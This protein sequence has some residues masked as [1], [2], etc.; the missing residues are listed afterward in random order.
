M[1]GVGLVYNP[2]LA[3]LI[4]SHREVLDFVVISPEQFFHDRGA[5]NKS[6][7]PRYTEHEELLGIMIDAVGDL[8]LVAH[9]LRLS[10]GTEGDL[11]KGHL[12]QMLRWQEAFNFRW[13]SE[14]LSFST[15]GAAFDYKELG[16]MLPVTYDEVTLKSLTKRVAE[17]SCVLPVEFLLENAVNYTPLG[18]C[19]YTEC[20]FLN[21][22]CQRTDAKLLLDLH[23]L[24][25]NLRN[26]YGA[27]EVLEAK[28]I[29]AI[30][31]VDISHIREI[32]IAGGAEI[33]GVW[34]DSHSGF[35]PEEVWN[36]LQHILS[37][38]HH[39][40]GVTYEID[41]SCVSL[42]GED[43]IVNMLRHVRQ[44]ITASS[45]SVLR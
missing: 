45:G 44:L 11:D 34:T 37:K 26:Q 22:L 14:H 25:T 7:L 6:S 17:V 21:E 23:N 19:D 4:R 29:E 12:Q 5:L 16:I 39:I 9:G 1:T 15:L 18:D 8:P 41:P 24:Y 2:A 40:R 33:D 30:N 27:G 38:P 28:L 3:H 10:I 42:I 36:A 35:C 32:H 31:E 43:E 20:H 13:Y